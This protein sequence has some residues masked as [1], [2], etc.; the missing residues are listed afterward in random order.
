MLPPFP[1]AK[2]RAVL[3]A[4][5]KTFFVR[6]AAHVNENHQVVLS[7][8]QLCV[9]NILFQLSEHQIKLVRLDVAQIQGDGEFFLALRRF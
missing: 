8:Q 5:Y 9:V 1:H 4:W 7:Q 6:L 3:A 2:P